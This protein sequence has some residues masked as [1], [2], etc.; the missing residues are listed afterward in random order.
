MKLLNSTIILIFSIH[1]CFSQNNLIGSR[2]I[3]NSQDS[4]FV[5]D[6]LPDTFFNN[7]QTVFKIVGR[8]LDQIV[9]DTTSKG[10]GIEYVRKQSDLLSFKLRSAPPLGDQKEL[11]EGILD[12]IVLAKSIV[13]LGDLEPVIES[14]SLDWLDGPMSSDTIYVKDS[15]YD[16]L[17]SIRV[18]R[19][20][21]SFFPDSLIADGNHLIGKFEGRG[22]IK[23]EIN[24]EDFRKIK[25]KIPYE[26]NLIDV[27]LKIAGVQDSIFKVSRIEFISPIVPSIKRDIASVIKYFVYPLGLLFFILLFRIANLSFFDRKKLNEIVKDKRVLSKGFTLH[28]CL[29]AIVLGSILGW[30]VVQSIFFN[31]DPGPDRDYIINTSTTFVNILVCVNVL[32]V[33]L[34]GYTIYKLSSVG[35]LEL[36][37]IPVATLSVFLVLIAP[38]VLQSNYRSIDISSAGI[39]TESV[40]FLLVLVGGTRGIRMANKAIEDE[41]AKGP[42]I[43]VLISM[44]EEGILQKGRMSAGQDFPSLPQYRVKEAMLKFFNVKK[45]KWAINYSAGEGVLELDRFQEID[46]L[47]RSFSEIKAISDQEEIKRERLIDEVEL[48]ASKIGRYLGFS[49]GQPFTVQNPKEGFNVYSYYSESLESVLPNPFP[50]IIFSGSS[51]DLGAFKEDFQSILN[52]L[53]ARFRFVVFTNSSP[54]TFNNDI[55]SESVS[56][57]ENIAYIHDQDYFETLASKKPLRSAIMDKIQEQ[58]D[59]ILFSPY[60]TKAPT[61]GDMFYGRKREVGTIVEKIKDGSIAILGARRMGKTSVLQSVQRELINK[62][63]KTIFYY[64]DCYHISDYDSFFRE[65]SNRWI[66]DGLKIRNYS[67]MLDFPELV[68]EI[69]KKYGKDYSI[70]FQLD[71]IDRLLKFDNNEERDE[72]FFRMLRSLAQE[73]RCQFIFSGERTILDQLANPQSCFFNFPVPVAL[74]VLDR[75]IAVDLVQTPMGLIGITIENEDVTK[76]IYEYTSGHPNLIQSLCELCVVQLSDDSSRVLTSQVVLQNCTTNDFQ[77]IYLE[78]F[79]SQSTPLEKAMGTLVAENGQGLKSEIIEGIFDFGF[80][81]TIPEVERGLRYLTLCQVLKS[82]GEIYS[83]KPIKFTEFLFS[84][85]LPFKLWMNSFLREY[86]DQNQ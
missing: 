48:L 17:A 22:I 64:L 31:P 33:G 24:Y 53:D 77:G 10:I 75:E 40:I 63:S 50:L 37:I 81:P 41:I 35:E 26:P 28:F 38:Y 6:I 47:A 68:V 74:D 49:E 29:S 51:F 72:K 79:W 18:L 73:K 85:G 20:H 15:N 1:F 59:L 86:N 39:W 7:A 23:T 66:I 34:F 21:I 52:Q 14:I 56:K 69:Q 82:E 46:D 61:T 80:N 2:S 42:S 30:Y 65:I 67:Q 5:Y 45:E 19:N 43:E 32:L 44:L 27:N 55:I 25:A 3:P 84:G 58:I 71:E 13:N 9:T 70:V 78:T 12:G 60:K 16:S 11:F 4:V 8:N 54:S 62:E 83:I 76:I 36:P 57:Y